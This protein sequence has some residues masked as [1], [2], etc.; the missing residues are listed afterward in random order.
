MPMPEDKIIYIPKDILPALADWKIGNTYRVKLVLK[1]TSMD[2]D[3]ASFKIVDATSMELTDKAN[4][5]FLSEGGS[6][7]K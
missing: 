4:E 3:G 5:F 1:Q 7:K 6:Y 2:E